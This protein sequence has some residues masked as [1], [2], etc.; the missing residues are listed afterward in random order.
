MHVYMQRPSKSFIRVHCTYYVLP[1]IQIKLYTRNE[2]AFTYRK[3]NNNELSDDVSDDSLPLDDNANPVQLLLQDDSSLKLSACTRLACSHEHIHLS[4]NSEGDHNTTLLSA[5]SDGVHS[6]SPTSS[7]IFT[8][9][10]H[11]TSSESLPHFIVSRVKAVLIGGIVW[12]YHS[13]DG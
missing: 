4:N 11:C 8:L 3:N 2:H 1:G 10:Y 6:R 9:C 13:M 12:M 5:S 7:K